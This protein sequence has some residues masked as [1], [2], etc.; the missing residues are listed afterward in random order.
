MGSAGPARRQ[1]PPRVHG[2]RCRRTAPGD[3]R[4]DRRPRFVAYAIAD[5][6]PGRFGLRR[7]RCRVKALESV[8]RVATTADLDNCLSRGHD[9]AD[10]HTDARLES[11]MS[12]GGTTAPQAPS[13]A[14][15][16][17]PGPGRTGG[18]SPR[19]VVC[20]LCSCPAEVMTA[21]APN[22]GI[23]GLSRRL[24]SGRGATQEPSNPVGQ[25]HAAQFSPSPAVP[26]YPK[27]ATSGVP[28][29][30]EA[31]KTPA[32]A[33]AARGAFIARRSTDYGG[34]WI[35]SRRCP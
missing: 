12:G 31:R 18:L 2:G 15:S 1:M 14:G 10:L 23:P 13:R 32:H 17:N 9:Y 16:E 5:V 19:E 24:F 27:T 33:R 4:A 6:E 3:G 21:A 11:A 7:H 34:P 28:L 20:G 22:R 35:A 29:A 25:A 8:E 26:E 30:F